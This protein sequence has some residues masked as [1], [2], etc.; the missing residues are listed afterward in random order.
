MTAPIIFLFSFHYQV[1][2]SL[3]CLQIKLA[4]LRK[5]DNKTEDDLLVVHFHTVIFEMKN[6]P[7]LPEG[8]T[9]DPLSHKH[10]GGVFFLLFL[11][12]FLP[13]DEM[14]GADSIA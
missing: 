6:T 8:D 4:F 10:A 1:S 11:F 12:F 5:R 3:S 13:G 14:S 2:P 9:G 7:L